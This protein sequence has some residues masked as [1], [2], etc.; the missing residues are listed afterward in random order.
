MS[1]MAAN[2]ASNTTMAATTTAIPTANTIN[3]VT[4]SSNRDNDSA[5]N[6][7]GRTGKLVVH[8]ASVSK[9][10]GQGVDHHS[11]VA[12]KVF[13]QKAGGVGA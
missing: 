2:V 4:I 9:D 6:L 5:S 8:V 10:G 13:Q 12:D 1:L 7:S 3:N 11:V